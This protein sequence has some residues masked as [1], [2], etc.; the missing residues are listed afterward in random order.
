MH[1]SEKPIAL[2]FLKRTSWL[3]VSNA[4]WRSINIIPV[5][6]PSSKPF[7]ILIRV[8]GS[9]KTYY[10]KSD[11]WVEIR[12]FYEYVCIHF[13]SLKP[14][15]SWKNNF[16]LTSILSP[17]F[18][19]FFDSSSNRMKKR[20]IS[21]R[22]RLFSFYES[23]KQKRKKKRLKFNL[24]FFCPLKYN[25]IIIYIILYYVILY[26]LNQKAKTHPQQMLKQV[27]TM[28]HKVSHR[29]SLYTFCPG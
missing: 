5:N 23:K 17:G 18:F 2:S 4:F 10:C 21:L 9:S 26:C 28:R 19:I 20:Q 27:R 11:D 12:K 16:C 22:V 25:L 13:S 14:S 29:E 8:P 6:R 3:I 7:R 1:P 24:G 15:L